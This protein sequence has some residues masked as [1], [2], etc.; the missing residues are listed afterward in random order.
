MTT[1]DNN[2]LI[3]QLNWRCAVKKFDASKRLSDSQWNTL[4]ESLTLTPSSY[5]L[6][7]WKFLVVTSE[8]I[9]ET[10][11]PFTWNQTQVKDCSHYVIFC[12]QKSL[13]EEYVKNFIKLIAEK[14]SMNVED[15]QG[16]Q[17][18]MIEDIVKGDRSKVAT[19]WASRQCYIALGNLMTSAAA[20]GIDTCPIEGFQPHKYDEIL[21]LAKENL[22]SAVCCA[23]GFR[24]QED[25]YAKL[26]KVRFSQEELFDYR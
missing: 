14:R 24:H 20:I 5:G 9:K 23:V 26:T 13:D 15:L 25:K 1:I 18:V 21:G 7:P 6:Q 11:T 3:E 22:T 10:L 16:Y 17:K 19:E 8:E 4:A 2:T 12:A